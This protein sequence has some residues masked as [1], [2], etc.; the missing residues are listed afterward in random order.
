MSGDWLSGYLDVRRLVM[1]V[2]RF[3]E[4]G[5]A[6]VI[7]IP[8]VI[9]VM[10]PMVLTPAHGNLHGTQWQDIT[11]GYTIIIMSGM[12]FQNLLR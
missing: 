8:E 7:E 2:S 4:T 11:F 6:L 10:G 5:Y 9:I 3:Q 1:R 12:L